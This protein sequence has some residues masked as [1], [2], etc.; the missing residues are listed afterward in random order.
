MKIYYTQIHNPYVTNNS[1][2]T[3]HEQLVSDK[4]KI[5][6][7]SL[8]TYNDLVQRG[9]FTLDY[10]KKLFTYTNLYDHNST[11][12]YFVSAVK[13]NI[14]FHLKHN[15]DYKSLLDK[16]QLRINQ[17]RSIQDIYKIPPIPTLFLKK[18][19]LRSMPQ[20]KLLFQSTSSGTKGKKS[21]VGYD[22]M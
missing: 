7:N 6:L 18:H 9:A 12:R 11:D 8:D 19:T 22:A 4:S 13:G 21:Q 3:S 2:S 17:I 10:R 1:S 20:E 16:K 5:G 15:P 14:S